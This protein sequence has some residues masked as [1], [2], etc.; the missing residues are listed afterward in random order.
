MASNGCA[1]QWEEDIIL[2]LDGELSAEQGLE[3]EKHLMNCPQCAGFFNQIAREER[4]LA[5]QLLHRMESTPRPDSIAPAVMNALPSHP[6]TF[7]QRLVRSFLSRQPVSRRTLAVAA[8]LLI[9]LVASF[10]SMQMA[11]VQQEQ[12]VLVARNGLSEPKP[13]FSGY[14]VENPDGDYFDLPDGS[15]LYATSGTFFTIESFPRPDSEDN[16]VAIDRRLRLHSGELFIRVQKRDED[17]FTVVSANSKTTVFGTHFYVGVTEPRQTVV[18]VRRGQVHV[19]KRARNQIGAVQLTDE[20]MTRV[21]TGSNGVVE[22]LR[23]HTVD[24]DLLNRLAYFYASLSEPVAQ[25]VA[26]PHLSENPGRAA[27]V[28]DPLEGR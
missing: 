19:D 1:R 24:T 23:S 4:L 8:T 9:C 3:V 5:G 16:P 21:T 25:R 2:Y 7:P 14:Y 12:V 10:I 20:R 26:H 17:A 27:S 11:P 28:P 6:Q 13:L 15:S 18:A 22:L